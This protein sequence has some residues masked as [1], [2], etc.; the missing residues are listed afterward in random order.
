MANGGKTSTRKGSG[1]VKAV[2]IL[3]GTVLV[4]GLGLVGLNLAHPP[5][6]DAVAELTGG[7][8]VSLTH[9]FWKDVSGALVTEAKLPGDED[10][11]ARETLAK[12]IGEIEAKK[13]DAPRQA[14]LA[15]AADAFV[16]AYRN[17]KRSAG[18]VRPLLAAARTALDGEPAKPGEG[19]KPA[20]PPPA[21]EEPAGAAP[22]ADAPPADVPPIDP[23][24]GGK[25]AEG[26]R[27][28]SR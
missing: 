27:S 20:E 17:K 8:H 19:E 3:M 16:T 26:G 15:K 22:P 21:G 25:P 28:G 13:G 7:W 9:Y 5:S 18:D 11:S 24:P 6:F 23:A 12:L 14:S 4:L 2:K 10:K 1:L